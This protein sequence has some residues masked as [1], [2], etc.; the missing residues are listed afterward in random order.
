MNTLLG[1]SYSKI[2]STHSLSAG[3]IS[4]TA[5]GLYSDKEGYQVGENG[6][7]NYGD[8]Q[9]SI[10]YNNDTGILTVPMSC[11][12]KYTQM[13]GTN[14][15][16]VISFVHSNNSTDYKEIMFYIEKV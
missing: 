3:G 11:K 4:G 12:G 15:K 9:N 16:I 6:I 2:P 7:L 14:D 13:A 1:M 5:L 10:L 8:L